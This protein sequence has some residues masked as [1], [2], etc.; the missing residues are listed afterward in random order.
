MPELKS[1]PVKSATAHRASGGFTLLEVVLAFSILA[2]GMT[3]AMQGATSSMRQ[4][5]QA[6]EHT[7]AA[8]HAQNLLDNAGLDAPLEPGSSRGRIEPGY[9]WELEV[10][11]YTPADEGL[12]ALEGLNAP[13]QLLEL[14][15]LIEWQRGAQRREARFRTLRA[16]LPGV[17][18]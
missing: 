12:V 18:P 13:V 6:S 15:L 14:D 1:P 2:L 3:L 7:K 17:R 5:Q 10:R 9:Q 8:L 4:A 16:T 11:E